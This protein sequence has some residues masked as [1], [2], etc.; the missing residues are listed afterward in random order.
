MT[1][2][3]PDKLL[4]EVNALSRNVPN[5]TIGESAVMLVRLAHKVNQL[6]DWIS[7][8]GKLPAKMNPACQYPDPAEAERVAA[9]FH[10][11]YEQL[12]P[13][14]GYKTREASAVPWTDVPEQNR[15]LMTATV[16]HLMQRGIIRA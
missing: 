2:I 16:M 7:M 8:G 5:T 6:V 1:E 3:D 9:A 12:A 15:T 10:A 13:E 11:A 4:E 14:H